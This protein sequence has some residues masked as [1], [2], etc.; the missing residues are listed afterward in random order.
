MPLFFPSIFAIALTLFSSTATLA[1]EEEKILRL[2]VSPQGYPP[3]TIV[4]ADGTFSGIIWDILALAAERKGYKLEG[5]EI[6]RKR[7]DDFILSGHIDA[8]PRAIEW[9]SKPERFTFTEP[10]V[11]VQEVFFK[12]RGSQ[13]EY[14]G[15]ESLAGKSIVTHLGYKYPTLEP[16]LASGRAERFDVQNERD[17][18]RYLVEGKYHDLAIAVREVGLWHIKREGWHDQLDYAPQPLSS[19]EYRL[20]FNKDNEA[21]VAW[22]N[23]ELADIKRS[24][25]LEVILD[26]YR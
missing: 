25:E 20:M 26:R 1:A 12:R 6:P 8:T 4:H 15:P 11:E 9:T 19:V 13:F 17:M 22:F 16:M 21:F 5:L 3:F 10:L 14:T 2:N 24:G 7:V 18:L 23:D